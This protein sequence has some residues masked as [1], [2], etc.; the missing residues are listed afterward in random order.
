MRGRRRPAPLAGR[1]R[2]WPRSTTRARACGGGA[3]VGGGRRRASGSGGRARGRGGGLRAAVTMG[4]AVGA[5]AHSTVDSEAS[6]LAMSGSTSSSVLRRS[7]SAATM[8]SGRPP[9]PVTIDC[10]LAS[11]S[12]LEAMVPRRSSLVDPF[13]RVSTRDQATYSI[14][15]ELSL[16]QERRCAAYTVFSEKAQLFT[17]ERL[18]RQAT[19]HAVRQEFSHRA[20]YRASCRSSLKAATISAPTKYQPSNRRRRTSTSTG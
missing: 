20:V 6:R 5:A 2:R 11:S 18:Y 3:R 12:A 14:Y 17:Q 1:S 13:T 9:A 16:T 15:T 4:P 7:G 10:T 8:F 19:R